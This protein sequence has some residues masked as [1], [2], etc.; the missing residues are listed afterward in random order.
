MSARPVVIVG[1]SAAGLATAEALRAGGWERRI[2]VIGEES[3]LPCDRPPLSKGILAGT[4]ESGAVQL[5]PPGRLLAVGAEFQ[6]G[7]R[8]IGLDCSRRVVTTDDGLEQEYEAL[9]IAAGV[10]P[11][12]LP[13]A[14]PGDTVTLRTLADSLALRDALG[15]TSRL[16]IVGAGFVGLE[17]A[18]TARK[19]GAEVTIVEPLE[20]PLA[21]RIGERAATGLIELHRGNGVDIQTGRSVVDILPGEGGSHERRVLLLDGSE[22]S[23]DIVLVAIGCQPNTEWLD[24]SGL[25]VRDGVVCDQ[26]CRAGE[27]VWAAGDIARWHHPSLGR[28]IRVEHRLNATEQGHAVARDILGEGAPFAS[29]PFFWT[30]H[31][32][33]KVQV[34]GHVPGSAGDQIYSDPA[35]GAFVETFSEGGWLAA[36]VGWNAPR[37]LM[38]ARR[39]LAAEWAGSS[40]SG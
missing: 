27:R 35:S 4:Q 1:A 13:F 29:V 19:H 23:A 39:A 30:D 15:P 9:V 24:G 5:L 28:E 33:V 36:A 3:E 40:A 18:A 25:V 37:Q 8:A 2:V 7:R 17:V 20:R 14:V 22:L 26:F 34:A 38:S 31:Y 6:L 11:R 12:Q 21:A 10:R 16:L 32:G